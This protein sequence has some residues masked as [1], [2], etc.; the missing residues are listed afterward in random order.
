[1]DPANVVTLK[2]FHGGKIEFNDDLEDGVAYVG[3]S[4]IEKDVDIRIGGKKLD[5]DRFEEE[6][7]SEVKEII[8]DVDAASNDEEFINVKNKKRDWVLN[9][10]DNR[11][12]LPAIAELLAKVSHRLCARNIFTNWIKTIKGAPLH[13][14]FWKAVKA[15]NE[16]Q[17]TN[18][19]EELKQKSQRAYTEM[20]AR[21]VKKFC[22]CFY[23]NWACTYVTC[24]NMAETFNSWI[25]KAREKPILTMLEK[26]RRQVMCRMVDKKAEAA[27][28]NS[29]VTPRIRAKLNDFRQASINWRAIEANTNVY[30]VQH[31]NNS[32]LSYYVRLDQ[33]NCACGYWGVNGIPCLHANNCNMC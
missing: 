10:Y 25:L 6:Y 19:M 1:T 17:F 2:C 14:L 21:N 16:K 31:I 30:E 4:S 7:V 8:D 32:N 11:G 12:L 27:K 28:C 29:D 9:R 13:K 33:R 24:N 5:E 20:C 26:I 22:R 3:G 15:Y 18:A 23:S